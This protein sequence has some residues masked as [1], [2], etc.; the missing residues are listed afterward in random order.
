[1]SE[2]V[3]VDA[4]LYLSRI[5]QTLSI[6]FCRVDPSFPRFIRA[7]AP[8]GV[9]E[10]SYRLDVRALQRHVLEDSVADAVMLQMGDGT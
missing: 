2:F 1:M 3:D 8:Q 10:A 4:D 5:F 9:I 6:R 7:E